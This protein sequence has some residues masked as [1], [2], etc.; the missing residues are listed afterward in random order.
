M[1]VWVDG[2]VGVGVG[3]GVGVYV[4]TIKRKPLSGM[5][6]NSTVVVLDTGFKSSRD[7]GTGSSFRTVGSSSHLANITD[8]YLL[9]KLR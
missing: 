2:W 6:R 5:T 4:S 9:R 3:V 8:Y 7:M 1:Y